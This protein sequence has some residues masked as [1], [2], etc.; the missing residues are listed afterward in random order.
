[1]PADGEL[2]REDVGAV[3]PA[4]EADL[5]HGD[6]HVDVGEPLESQAGGD[7][8]EGETLQVAL[9]LREE[10]EDLLAR[11]HRPAA[12]L[13]ELDPLAEIHQVRRGV[14][15][16]AKPRPGEGG[17]EHRAHRALAVGP[18][19]VHGTEPLRRMAQG[20]VQAPHPVQSRLVGAGREA[21]VLYA[22]MAGVKLLEEPVVG[23]FC[24]VHSCN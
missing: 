7:F 6:V 4:A 24:Q 11:D 2:G 16:H 8:E 14:E 10:A 23:S 20:G 12:G 5:D 22:R 3:Q 19:H 15:T 1:M 13:H 9:P 21:L 17:R 18:G